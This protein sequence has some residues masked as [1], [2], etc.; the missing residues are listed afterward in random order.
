MAVEVDDAEVSRVRVDEAEVV[1]VVVGVVVG[2][3]V[4]GVAS[5]Y[6]QRNG[7]MMSSPT[8]AKPEKRLLPVLAVV[9]IATASL[10]ILQ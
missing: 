6:S 5:S 8:L 2:G 10:M 3:V 9:A 7:K 4:G 1:G